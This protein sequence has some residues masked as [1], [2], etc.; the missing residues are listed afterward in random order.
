MPLYET[1]IDDM[2]FITVLL[3]RDKFAI[4]TLPEELKSQPR[5]RKSC[6]E[7]LVNAMYKHHPFDYNKIHWIES[8]EG[9]ERMELLYLTKY[10]DTIHI[11]DRTIVKRSEVY[12]PI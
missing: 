6:S 2:E 3:D 12:I 1:K 8:F 10:G 7:L 4:N 9:E 5:K 11:T